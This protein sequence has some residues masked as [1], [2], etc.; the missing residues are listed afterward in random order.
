MWIGARAREH[1]GNQNSLPTLSCVL[2]EARQD[3]FPTFSLPLL[4]VSSSSPYCP[5]SRSAETPVIFHSILR[6]PT[7][8]SHPL[9]RPI[10]F[11]ADILPSIPIAAAPGYLLS[12]LHQVTVVPPPHP[13]VSIPAK[14]SKSIP[15]KVPPP[16]WL[17]MTAPWVPQ[18]S[19][20]PTDQQPQ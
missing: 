5:L 4:P 9:P 11:Q 14:P 16:A 15:P 13:S 17:P 18:A 7:P 1:L 3:L 20:C 8:T 19:Y 12:P 10:S 2:T 6:V